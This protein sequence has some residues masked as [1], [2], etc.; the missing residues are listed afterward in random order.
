M[1]GCWF[2]CRR[3]G[4]TDLACN[5][6]FG[7]RLPVSGDESVAVPEGT[8]ASTFSCRLITLGFFRS[9]TCLAGG[10]SQNC[11][12]P[13]GALTIEATYSLP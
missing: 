6:S 2:V 5:D 13:T 3:V 4:C 7:R 11:A 10:T 1:T 9:L 8:V 12:S